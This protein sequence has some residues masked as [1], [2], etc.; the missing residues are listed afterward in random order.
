MI[1]A[2][3][4]PLAYCESNAE[5]DR[6]QLKRMTLN[7]QEACILMEPSAVWLKNFLILVPVGLIYSFISFRSIFDS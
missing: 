5:R 2:L 3:I 4:G 6:Q 1:L 7:L